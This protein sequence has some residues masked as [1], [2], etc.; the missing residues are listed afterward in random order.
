MTGYRLSATTGTSVEQ[1]LL[2]LMRWVV[3]RIRKCGFI[4]QQL[5]ANIIVR[6]LRVSSAAN[7]HPWISVIGLP[8]R[9][10]NF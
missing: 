1:S 10:A 3:R 6:T 4:A 7:C 8:K 5:C 9:W 2:L